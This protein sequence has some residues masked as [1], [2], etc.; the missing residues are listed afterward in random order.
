MRKINRAGK[1]SGKWVLKEWTGPNEDIMGE[2]HG[3]F[4]L[5]LSRNVPSRWSILGAFHFPESI[6]VAMAFADLSTPELQ[7][8]LM[9][10]TKKLTLGLRN[11]IP[12]DQKE[13][14]RKKIEVIQR[15]LEE[16]SGNTNARNSGFSC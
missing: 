16:R 6:L 7:Q 2:W 10:E 9:D 11:R 13:E 4:N 8:L 5:I 14:L 12:R 1:K 3:Y 15:I